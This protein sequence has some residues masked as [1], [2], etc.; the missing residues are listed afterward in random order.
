MKTS[1]SNRANPTSRLSLY[2]GPSASDMARILLAKASISIRLE[3]IHFLGPALDRA[4]SIAATG[5]QLGR[6]DLGEAVKNSGATGLSEASCSLR[7]TAELLDQLHRASFPP[8]GK[9][10]APLPGSPAQREVQQARARRP[11][12]TRTQSKHGAGPTKVACRKSMPAKAKPRKGRS[13]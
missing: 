8:C 12:G 3:W 10:A 1:R 13:A 5:M 6:H 11:S 4:C 7:Y 2:T 9:E